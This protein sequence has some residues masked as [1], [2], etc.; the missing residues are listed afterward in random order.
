MHALLEDIMIVYAQ[1]DPLSS[2]H[3]GKRIVPFTYRF[4]TVVKN[5]LNAS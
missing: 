2:R 1:N 4:Q 3:K 5:S